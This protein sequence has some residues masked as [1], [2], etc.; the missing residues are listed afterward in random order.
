MADGRENGFLKQFHWGRDLYGS[1]GGFHYCQ[2]RIK[3]LSSPKV[4]LRPQSWNT[5]F[6]EVIR[7]YDFIKNENDPCIYKKISGSSVAHLVLYVNDILL[8]GNGVKVF[9]D[10]K[11]WL[12]TQFFMKDMGEASYI[13]GIK[14]YRGRSK[15]ILGLTQASYIEKV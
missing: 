3:G 1:A 11:A 10:I 14:I 13:L 7:G 6:D 9:S 15:R 4:H 2:R 12:S 8:I 5:R